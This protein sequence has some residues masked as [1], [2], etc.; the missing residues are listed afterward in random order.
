MSFEAFGIEGTSTATRHQ[1]HV[2]T[3]KGFCVQSINIIV[4]IGTARDGCVKVLW[5]HRNGPT[6]LLGLLS[7][8][9][10][11]FVD[12]AFDVDAD[13]GRAELLSTD[14]ADDS[15]WSSRDSN[16]LNH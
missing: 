13:T 4:S 15:F 2:K 8:N 5:G 1:R 16:F 10:L 14:I 11:P 7:L 9:L 6:L 3:I 12:A